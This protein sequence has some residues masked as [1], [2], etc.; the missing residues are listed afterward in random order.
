VITQ[1]RLKE[2]L[3]YEPESGIFTWLTNSPRGRIGEQAGSVGDRN[4]VWIRINRH[5]YRAHRL[6]WLY[7]HGKFPSMQIDHIDG[8]P[9]NNKINNLR[10]VDHKDNQRN[11]KLRY[12]NNTGVTGVTWSNRDKCFISGIKVNGKSKH[13]YRG[14][15]LLDAVA[16]RKSAEIKY[17][18]HENHGRSL[19]DVTNARYIALYT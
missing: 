16:F 7:I 10:E 15:C 8:D 13:L 2:I 5:P 14:K 9:T 3:N 12:D 6:A 19:I 1:K 11:A 4:Y 17:G 18:F